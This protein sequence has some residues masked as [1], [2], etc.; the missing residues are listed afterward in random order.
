MRL[1]DAGHIHLPWYVDEV[2][3]NTPRTY[4]S[5]YS[6]SQYVQL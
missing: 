1:L 6:S 3:S 2:G 5:D 4:V